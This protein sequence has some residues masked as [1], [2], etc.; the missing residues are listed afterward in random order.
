[1]NVV[2]SERGFKSIDL[3][4]HGIWISET[5]PQAADIFVGKIFATGR[6]PKEF[7]AFKMFWKL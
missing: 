3:N 5:L 1:M 7:G 4:R 6:S 2:S